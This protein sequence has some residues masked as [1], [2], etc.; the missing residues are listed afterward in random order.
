MILIIIWETD[1]LNW[2]WLQNEKKSKIFFFSWFFS[3]LCL[4]LY[5]ANHSSVYVQRLE[6]NILRRT[7]SES[8]EIQIQIQNL[9]FSPRITPAFFIL[10][11]FFPSNLT[12]F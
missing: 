2:A 7:Q 12:L 1:N 4:I 3:L 11:W 6:K 5:T 10:S 9:D 8:R